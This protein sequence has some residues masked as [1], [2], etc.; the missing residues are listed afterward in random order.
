MTQGSSIGSD[1]LLR[2]RD[3]QEELIRTPIDWP[4]ATWLN[5]NR[6]AA[7]LRRLA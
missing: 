7:A 4:E 5:S 1:R 6:T 3:D 2:S